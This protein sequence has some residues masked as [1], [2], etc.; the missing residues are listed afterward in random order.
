MNTS[1]VTNSAIKNLHEVFMQFNVK[2][3]GKSMVKKASDVISNAAAHFKASGSSITASKKLMQSRELKDLKNAEQALRNF[4]KANTIKLGEYSIISPTR[5]LK[6]KEQFNK[7]VDRH[8][9]AM[10]IFIANVDKIKQ[11]DKTS[12]GLGDLYNESDYPS[13]QEIRNSFGVVWIVAP[14]PDMS[15]LQI[16][17]LE[18]EDSEALLT[19]LN[20][21]VNV[22]L[23][24]M[25]QDLLN[26]II[27]GKNPDTNNIIDDDGDEVKLGNGLLYAIHRLANFTKENS[28]KQNTID[29]I[30]DVCDIVEDLNALGDVR[31]SNICAN[32]KRIF[33]KDADYLR[34][35]DNDRNEVVMNAQEQLEEIEKVME[36]FSC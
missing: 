25:Y 9:E 11:Q 28:F 12:A 27:Y 34:I 23:S 30:K 2:I 7:L 13:E 8:K 14:L 22:D 21:L 32:L 24:N 4:I 10:D 26:K 31:I 5:F 1:I 29:N 20:D 36:A 15:N 35:D 18:K 16:K 6:I 19:K 17:G 33:N 3:S